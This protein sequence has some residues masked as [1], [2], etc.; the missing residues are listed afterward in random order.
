MPQ[1]KNR[2]PWLAVM[3]IGAPIIVC[4]LSMASVY[5]QK[6]QAYRQD[7]DD[8]LTIAAAL[9]YTPDHYIRSYREAGGNTAD[10]LRVVYYSDESWE[11]FVSRVQ[12][13]GFTQR[14]YAHNNGGTNSLFLEMHV[15]RHLT[16]SFVTLNDHYMRK[17]FFFLN[18][19]AP[20]ITEWYLRDAQ[21]RNIDIYY[22]QTPGPTD[23]WKYNG[24]VMP[25]NIVLVT[26]DRRADFFTQ[27][28]PYPEPEE[29]I[30]KAAGP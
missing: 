12:A 4:V 27:M 30:K 22:A 24:E 19:P 26:F 9:D 6:Q 10:I 11:Q 20:I 13:L 15:N 17:D 8:L 28:L 3:L 16:E 2:I 1:P 21:S 29:L 7:V 25:G 23:V 5:Y 18:L 14:L